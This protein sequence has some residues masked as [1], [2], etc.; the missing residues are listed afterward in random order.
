[1]TEPHPSPPVSETVS[2]QDDQDGTESEPPPPS[3]R[4]TSPSGI[5]PVAAL[6]VAE[7]ELPAIGLGAPALGLA[8]TLLLAALFSGL[9]ASLLRSLPST[10]GGDASGDDSAEEIRRHLGPDLER[11]ESLAA[12]AS[13]AAFVFRAA[14]I[15]CFFLLVL[16][17]T[18]LGWV[19]TTLVTALGGGL[20]LHLVTQSLPLAV[21]QTRTYTLL[22]HAL[23]ALAFALV[24]FGI[25]ARVLSAIRR[26]I[27]RVFGVPDA[28]YGT[29]RLVEGFRAMVEESSFDGDLAD[30]T[31][32]MLAN[33][34]EFGAADAAEVMTPRTE[35]CAID[36]DESLETAIA[37]FAESGFSR[38]PVYADTIDTVIGTLTTLEAAKAIAE[39]RLGETR[40]VDV[41]RPPLLIPETKL[42]AELLND[43]R[44][45]KQK[46]AIVVDEYGGTA[47]LVTLAD[48]VSEVLGNV[49]D[50]FTE[51]DR[52]FVPT[53]RGTVDVDASLHV[54]E[55]NEELG[56]TIQEEADYETLAGFVLSEIGRFPL[57]GEHFDADGVRYV[58]REASDRRVLRVEIDRSGGQRTKSIAASLR[59][60]AATKDQRDERPRERVRPRGAGPSPAGAARGPA[61]RA[62]NRRGKNAESRTS[63]DGTVPE[64][65]GFDGD[66]RS[67]LAG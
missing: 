51:E 28:R 66:S 61:P 29:R 22:A 23:P 25:L 37:M 49:D 42:A 39:G 67:E 19:G 13:L 16:H 57:S 54:A 59:R 18:T 2:P 26:P 44:A 17:G 14:A 41:I 9:S 27:L 43:F 62:T 50:E 8:G 24:P 32:E 63:V 45:Q 21:A 5:V 1:M 65:D 11:A 40:I 56:L 48:V 64:E 31:R 33:V 46:M 52:G 3:A 12:S 38:I 53:D 35:M 60:R 55:V 15:A 47:G 34:I 6:F 36:K 58:V 4:L 10:I 7:T 30:E 20:V